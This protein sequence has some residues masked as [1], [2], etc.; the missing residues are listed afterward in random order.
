[1]IFYLPMPPSVN[2]MYI[3]RKVKGRTGRSLG[4][5]YRAWR[6][7]AVK[8][9][10]RQWDEQG[11]PIVIAPL[12]VDIG[13]NLNRRSDLDNR[14]KACLDALGKAIPGMPD[15]RW[16]DDLR[17]YRDPTIEGARVTVDGLI[18]PI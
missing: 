5:G 7:E 12:A 1:M 2:E 3:I 18:R 17:V 13:I 4:W 16:I 6:D 8:A 11:K 10:K 9:M 14:V 15:D